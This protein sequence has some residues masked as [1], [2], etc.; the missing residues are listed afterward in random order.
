M[1]IEPDQNAAVNEGSDRCCLTQVVV[2]KVSSQK[3]KLSPVV[4]QIRTLVVLITDA[5]LAYFLPGARWPISPHL[6][7]ASFRHTGLSLW[8]FAS[9]LAGGRSGHRR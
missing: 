7:A 4:A 6:P 9:I 1:W 5:D 2:P 3:N 8:L